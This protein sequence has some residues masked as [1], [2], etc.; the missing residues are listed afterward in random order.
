MVVVFVVVI[1][2][3]M[4]LM[5]VPPDYSEPII[6]AREDVNI[7]WEIGMSASIDL[8]P[9]DYQVWAPDIDPA[10]PDYEHFNFSIHDLDREVVV[11]YS[12]GSVIEDVDGAP[13]ELYCS[14]VLDH[15]EGYFYETGSNDLGGDE[16]HFVIV[17]TR[18]PRWADGPGVLIGMV[19][20]IMGLVVGIVLVGERYAR[21]GAPGP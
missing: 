3:G 17:F 21:R 16:D 2:A 9:G 1:V 8:P 11:Q 15:G 4:A 6:E 14:F 13:H 12:D 20:V 18:E 5:M 19:M 7:Y 10:K